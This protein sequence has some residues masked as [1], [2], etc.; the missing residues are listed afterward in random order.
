MPEKYNPHVVKTLNYLA[1]LHAPSGSII[2]KI[3][4]FLFS[5]RPRGWAEKANAERA[6]ALAIAE[7]Y[8]ENPICKSILEELKK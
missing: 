8:P 7:Q 3:V 6:E 1:D 4:N 5:R 2:R